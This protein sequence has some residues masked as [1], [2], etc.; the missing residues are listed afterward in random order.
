MTTQK[1][2]LWFRQ[3]A[4]EVT[5]NAAAAQYQLGL[6]AEVVSNLME[7]MGK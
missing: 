5:H 3:C 4:W 6:C 7:A 2:D 1:L